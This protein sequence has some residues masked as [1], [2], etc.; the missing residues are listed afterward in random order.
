[1]A[2]PNDDADRQSTADEAAEPSAPEPTSAPEKGAAKAAAGDTQVIKDRNRR[3]REEAAAKRRQKRAT[4]ERRVAP[5]R[6]LDTS[7]LVD[8]AMARTTHAVAQFLRRNFNVVQYVVLAAVVGGIGYQIY[9]YRHARSVAL[10]ADELE[11]GVRAEHARVGDATEPTPD[12]YTGLSDT[13]AN[14]PTDEARL[15]AAE[16]EY[17]KVVTDGSATT[18]ALAS[19]ALGGIYFDQGKYKD[20]QAAYEK[21]KS[22]PLAKVD[23]DAR[24]RAIEGAGLSLEAAGQ[25]DAALTAFRELENSDIPGFA[26]LGQY[27][28]ARLLAQKGQRSEA[29]ALLEKALKK[30][31]EKSDDAKAPPIAPGGGYLEH[32]ARELMSS[33]DPTAA[34]K[35][36]GAAF[37]PEEL[38]R[39]Q[40]ELAGANGKIDPQKLQELLKKMGGG[41]APGAPAAPVEAPGTPAPEGPSETP[42]PAGSAP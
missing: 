11:K 12:Q 32:Q 25:L 13:R 31:S 42:N 34:P 14:Y 36:T 8:D 30:L 22:S 16:A 7:E 18:S 9:S 40:A 20:A 39:L 26:P 15:K 27:H 1:M 5:A 28:Q 4:E 21:V 3:I 37:D 10:A 19:L 23:P 35:T 24:A 29:K 41:K 17:K 33:I 6:N 2:E 38:N